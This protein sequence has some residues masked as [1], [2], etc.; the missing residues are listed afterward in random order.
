MRLRLQS[1]FATARL[2]LDGEEELTGR[3]PDDPDSLGRLVDYY[4]PQTCR[5]VTSRVRNGEL[6][7]DITSTVLFKALRAIG[8]CRPSSHPAAW[9]YRISVSVIT[10]QQHSRKRS[11]DCLEDRAELVAPALRSARRWPSGCGSPYLGCYR[12]RA[13]WHAGRLA[14]EG[15]ASRRGLVID[16]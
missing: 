8:C 10:D 9:R 12:H 16:R 7:E 3:A 1:R 15:S 14:T 2:P 4:F 6:A 11:E 13:D 5:N